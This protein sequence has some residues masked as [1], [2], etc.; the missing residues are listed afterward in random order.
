MYTKGSLTRTAQFC[1]RAGFFYP[2]NENLLAKM[3]I[4]T[5]NM[6]I[7]L[8]PKKAIAVAWTKHQKR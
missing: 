3:R 5:S 6:G 8:G 2:E 1:P 7:T 4:D